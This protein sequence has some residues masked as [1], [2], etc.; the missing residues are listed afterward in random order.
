MRKNLLLTGLPGVGKTTVLRR[1][2]EGL[3]PEAIHGFFTEETRVAGQRVGFGIQTF[4]GQRATLAHV[5]LPSP[6]RVGRYKVGLEALDRIVESALPPATAM[7]SYLIDEIGKMECLSPQ[8]VAAVE[9][10]L[11]GQSIVVATVAKKG[12][13]FIAEVKRRPDVEAWEVIRA[14]R[15]ALPTAV[16]QWLAKR[17]APIRS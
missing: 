15:D 1:V 2:A 13:G 4:D 5:A 9:R 6:H 3:A 17:G 16:L 11:D 7:A 14:N 12:S 8:F 10:M